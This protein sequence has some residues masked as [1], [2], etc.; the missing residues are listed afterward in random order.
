MSYERLNECKG[1]L[2]RVHKISK[3]SWQMTNQKASHNFGGGVA[4]L[5]CVAIFTFFFIAG[6]NGH[7][8]PVVGDDP[9]SISRIEQVFGDIEN[10]ATG[11][12]M[13]SAT[14]MWTYPFPN[15]VYPGDI[16]EQDTLFGTP[17]YPKVTAFVWRD[18]P[19][20]PSCINLLLK[21]KDWNT[22]YTETY[23]IDTAL[24]DEQCRH[25]AVE[26]TYSRLTGALA[27]TLRVHIVWAQLIPD[28]PQDWDICYCCIS[29]S[30]TQAGIDWDNPDST[31]M[32]RLPACS[33]SFDEIEPDICILP[34]VDS[35]FAVCARRD[36]DSDDQSIVAAQHK[37]AQMTQVGS[38][39]S[40]FAV[41]NY[42]SQPKAAPTI[43]AG[44]FTPHSGSGNL[45]GQVAAVW[46]EVAEDPGESGNSRYQ[47][48]YNDWQRNDSANP[49]GII[50]ISGCGEGGMLHNGLPKI[51]IPSFR[52]AGNGEAV[53]TW[54]AVQETLDEP[55][56]YIGYR[57]EMTATPDLGIG[58]NDGV[59]TVFSR[60]PDVACFQ[61]SGTT[62]YVAFSYYHTDDMDNDPWL[63]YAKSYS[64]D[65]ISDVA[66][67]T[68][69][70]SAVINASNGFWDLTEE[71]IFTGSTICLQQAATD[72]ADARLALGWIDTSD[73]DLETAWGYIP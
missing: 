46:S 28:D 68:L 66:T 70:D 57:V 10:P 17:I 48:F 27:G 41:S 55:P 36:L 51:D 6:C 49:N 38:W 56:L 12:A 34:S 52:A 2:G 7:S 32:T 71:S 58:H 45:S 1:P 40:A 30:V 5:F 62:Q 69:E 16:V 67:F 3:G 54:M 37:H 33:S 53:I 20:A 72:P 61:N 14:T 59:D 15:T 13:D 8:N 35:L 11:R 39:D 42:D 43:D 23:Y 22:V 60:C 64:Y 63:V 47:V 44:M 31:D 73:C 29:Y 4:A 24:E 25:P 26:V 19:N 50:Q 21:D 65:I 18:K 9:E